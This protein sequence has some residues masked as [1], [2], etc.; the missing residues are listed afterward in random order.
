MS[1]EL[2]I[3]DISMEEGTDMLEPT[4]FKYR[5]DKLY[6]FHL[7]VIDCW[8]IYTA[9]MLKASDSGGAWV[10][11]HNLP[12]LKKDIPA[13]NVYAVSNPLEIVMDYLH[14]LKRM[15]REEQLNL[16]IIQLPT[17]QDIP[18]KIGMSFKHVMFNQGQALY[19]PDLYGWGD[20]KAIQER[21]HA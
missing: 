1:D 11:E 14:S 4:C 13:L 16:D 12:V 3:H 18:G 5:F 19:H 9:I 15:V 17:C 8:D 6:H 7:A 2:T 21:Q 10:M 20:I